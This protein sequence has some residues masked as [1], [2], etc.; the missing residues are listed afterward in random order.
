MFCTYCRVE[1][2]PT[3]L[4][5]LEV[6]VSDTHILERRLINVAVSHFQPPHEHHKTQD[7]NMNS[8]TIITTL[9]VSQAVNFKKLV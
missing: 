8:T 9:K 4:Q 2:Q 1:S 7:A 6:K 5:V 3:H